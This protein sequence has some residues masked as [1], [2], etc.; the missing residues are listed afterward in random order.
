MIKERKEKNLMNMNNIIESLAKTFNTLS[1]I[2]TKGEDTI[3][4]GEC[5]KSIKNIYDQLMI[6]EYPPQA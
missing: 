2:S 4:M 6:D 5:L 3:Y 1:L